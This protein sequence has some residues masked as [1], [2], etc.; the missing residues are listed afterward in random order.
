ME[1][2]VELGIEGGREETSE[3][4]RRKKKEGTNERLGYMSE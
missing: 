1:R 3:H 4:D 2:E